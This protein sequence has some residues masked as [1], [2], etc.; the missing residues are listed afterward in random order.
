MRIITLTPDAALGR[1]RPHIGADTLVDVGTVEQFL[2]A[3][4]SGGVRWVIVDPMSISEAGFESAIAAIAGAG[5]SV[6]FY[7]LLAGFDHSRLLRTY[8]RLL[9]E[10]VF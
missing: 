2:S 10:V 4:R 9:P 5:V 8:D 1:L 7:S 6:A 3:L